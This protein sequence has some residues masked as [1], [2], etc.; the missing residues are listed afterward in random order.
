MLVVTLVISAHA[1]VPPVQCVV[2]NLNL[3]KDKVLIGGEVRR[4]AWRVGSP[5][6]F[7]S[8]YTEGVKR[9]IGA[10]RSFRS[11]PPSHAS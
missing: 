10:S 9:R 7:V 2:L 6:S 3:K 4:G 5:F 1:R 11:L 8:L